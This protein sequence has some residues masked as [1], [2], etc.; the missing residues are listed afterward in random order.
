MQ[1]NACCSYGSSKLICNGLD[2]I[3]CKFMITLGCRPIS[4]YFP[5][6]VAATTP[7]SMSRKRWR[8][9][10]TMALINCYRQ[11]SALSMQALGLLWGVQSVLLWHLA[12]LQDIGQKKSHISLVFHSQSQLPGGCQPP[13]HQSVE[14]WATV[15]TERLPRLSGNVQIRQSLSTAD[16]LTSLYFHPCRWMICRIQTILLLI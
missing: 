1:W 11:Y 15:W 9:W 2:G 14:T 7:P 3:H 12:R 13:Q 16:V 10:M 8:N 4:K 6:A 5:T